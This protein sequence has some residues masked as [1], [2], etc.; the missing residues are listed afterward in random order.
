MAI[1]AP[2]DVAAGVEVRVACL[3]RV[4]GSFNCLIFTIVILFR[5]F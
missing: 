5:Q 1:R 3:R 4:A 2:G